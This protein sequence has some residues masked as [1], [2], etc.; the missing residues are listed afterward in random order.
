MPAVVYQLASTLNP[1]ISPLRAYL[2]LI[3]LDGGLLEEGFYMRGGAYRIILDIKKT[4]FKDLV[5]SSRNFFMG[6]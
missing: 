4:L 3:F 6:I 2:F 5:Y 1:R